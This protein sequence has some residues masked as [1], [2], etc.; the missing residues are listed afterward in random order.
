MRSTRLGSTSPIVVAAV[1][2]T[3]ASLNSVAQAAPRTAYA[4]V[5]VL[6]TPN[7]QCTLTGDGM[8]K[9]IYLWANEIGVVRFSALQADS[10]G[11]A[12]RLSLSCVDEK[13]SGTTSSLDLRSTSTFQRLSNV[14]I[15]LS[16]HVRPALV[17][18]PMQYSWDELLREGYGNRPDPAK[19][20]AAYARWLKHATVQMTEAS[21]IHPDLNLNGGAGGDPP[22]K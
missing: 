13:G 11:P 5:E 4:P 16:A 9:P 7:A 15:P 1:L 22:T 6:A 10:K 18:D 2:S 19:R 12:Q 21:T 17:G 20:P 8:A 14:P 3:G